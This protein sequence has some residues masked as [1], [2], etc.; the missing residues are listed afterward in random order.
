MLAAAAGED[1]HAAGREGRAEGRLSD[2]PTGD[3]VGSRAGA[4]APGVQRPAWLFSQHLALRRGFSTC[5]AS[6]STCQTRSTQCKG[7]S[8]PPVTLLV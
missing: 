3:S 4:R 1:V 6:G 2:R 8:M 5:S 7:V